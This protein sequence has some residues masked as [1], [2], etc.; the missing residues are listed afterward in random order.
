MTHIDELLRSLDPAT[1][2]DPDGAR[3]QA[4][5]ARILANDS[6]PLPPPPPEPWPG[7]ASW[8]WRY[9]RIA[10]VAGLVVIA[11]VAA[12]ILPSALGGD[13]A[14][15][16]WTATPTGLS[17]SESAKAASACRK[18]QKSGSPDYSDQLAT[19]STAIS[20]RRGAWTLVTLAGPN[21]FSALCITDESTRLFKS[22]FG[23]IGNTATA[24]RRDLLA[25]GLGTG[26]SDGRE[27]SVAEGSAGSDVKAVT[28]TS[29]THG[30]VKAT[31]SGGRFALW[32]PGPGINSHN[33]PVQV[34]YTDGTTTTLTLSL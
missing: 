8:P 21:G 14:F 23:S 13:K 32:F 16:T 11:A 15:A 2:I 6:A 1:R 24:G 3:A 12:L 29:A 9:V 18:Q 27:L 28:Y 10:L 5:L 30:L 17:P 34:T 22:Y 33:T 20:E 19:A 26:S 7:P 4:D 31:V 25:T